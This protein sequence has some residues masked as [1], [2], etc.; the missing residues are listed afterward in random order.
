MRREYDRV[1][2]HITVMNSIFRKK[3]TIGHEN[4]NDFQ[5]PV[6][7]VKS[8]RAIGTR[9][10]FDAKEILDKFGTRHFCTTDIKEMHLSQ[11]RAG[12]RNEDN[13]YCPSTVVRFS[14]CS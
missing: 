10:S 3:E 14:T 2:L 8:E 11:L 9:E 1:K 7:D 5:D 6:F 13:Y 4:G 12:R